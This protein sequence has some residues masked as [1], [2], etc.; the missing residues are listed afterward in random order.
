MG[1]PGK[2]RRESSSESGVRVRAQADLNELPVDPDI[3]RVA[4]A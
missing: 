4:D 2:A 1:G 3:R